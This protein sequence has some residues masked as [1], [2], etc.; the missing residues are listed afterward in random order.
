MDA[1]LL[2]RTQLAERLLRTAA[3]HSLGPDVEVDWS[4]L[5]VPGLLWMPE[6]RVTL[7]GTPLWAASPPSS[8][9]GCRSTA[10]STTPPAA[11]C[12]AAP[13]PPD[14]GCWGAS[15]LRGGLPAAGRGSS[16]HP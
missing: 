3:R 11:C 14:T 16:P 10:C 2:P 13:A 8:G 7:Y 1:T 5:P 9:S 12:S 15:P 6:H 4:A